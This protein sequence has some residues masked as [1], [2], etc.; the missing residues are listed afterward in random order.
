MGK[1]KTLYQVLE[2]AA[3]ASVQEVVEAHGKMLE[4]LHEAQGHLSREDFE[5]QRNMLGVARD[6]LSDPLLRRD[7]DEKLMARLGAQSSAGGSS[8]RALAPSAELSQRA[9]T[10]A[11]RADALA[12]RADALAIRTDTYGSAAPQ[13]AFERLVS[14][15]GRPLKR[16]AIVLGTLAALAV[17]AQ[18]LWFYFG[19]R[20]VRNVVES[21]AQA[22]ER[23]V[24]E[25]YYRRHGVRPANATEARLLEMEH[26]RKQDEAEAAER[27]A[28]LA[29]EN[30]RR[31]EEDARRAGERV[32]SNLRYAE[33]AARREEEAERRQQEREAF[34]RKAEEEEQLRM[35]R[36]RQAQETERA[37]R[38]D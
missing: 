11:L 15:L 29:E 14:G 27:E 25:E 10:L 30:A 21:A 22:E 2:I 5:Y 19:V 35:A 18:S 26:Q 33:E 28:R 6:T 1:K 9:E 17:I 20:K 24:V 4:K 37:R 16:I 31:F 3:G 12:L 36:M 8:S 32:S 23:M 38:S 34:R 13:S 7:Y